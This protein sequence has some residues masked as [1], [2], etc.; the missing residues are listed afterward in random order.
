[1]AVHY[2]APHEYLT[3]FS[4][5]ARLFPARHL[6][7]KKKKLLVSPEIFLDFEKPSCQIKTSESKRS[8]PAA[9]LPIL[10]VSAFFH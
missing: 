6:T 3:Y 1:M 5:S 2:A 7:I 8:F 10:D 4:T 9:F